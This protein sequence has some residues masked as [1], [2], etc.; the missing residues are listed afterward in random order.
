MLLS[1]KIYKK[2]CGT[3]SLI[4]KMVNNMKLKI[5]INPS[6]Q[7]I[8][9]DCSICFGT[10]SI[11][12]DFT[13]TIACALDYWT[14]ENYIQ[15]WKYALQRIKTHNTSCLVASIQDPDIAPYLNWWIMYKKDNKVYI[16]NQQLIGNDAKDFLKNKPFT[17]SSCYTFIPPKYT[18]H[19]NDGYDYSEWIIEL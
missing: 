4:S 18:M 12:D 19:P 15:Q 2:R 14:I 9:N 17:I 13:E 5:T 7:T 1:V 8:E 3:Y 11:G 10:M 16:S 6:T